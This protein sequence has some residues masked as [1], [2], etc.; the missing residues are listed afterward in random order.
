MRS[1]ALTGIVAVVL[2]IAWGL[3]S[4]TILTEEVCRTGLDRS[5]FWV[6]MLADY[7]LIAAPPNGRP[8]MPELVNSLALIGYVL[9]LVV[10]EWTEG[11]SPLDLKRNDVTQVIVWLSLPVLAAALAP[12][13]PYERAR[14]PWW[15]LISDVVT[16]VT[17]DALDQ[18]SST[19]FV[20]VIHGSR[21][22]EW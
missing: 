3:V 2:A 22:L 14:W 11:F 8:A 1:Q 20:Y 9:W 12:R 16:V 17:Y 5:L 10:I 21:L 15:L 18:F 7:G 19:G 6:L 13:R 4:G